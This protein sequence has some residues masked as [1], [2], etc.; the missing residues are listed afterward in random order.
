MFNLHILAFKVCS[1]NKA[2]NYY[3]L[4]CCTFIE[5]VGDNPSYYEL[6][7]KNKQMLKPVLGEKLEE[8]YVVA[9][10]LQ[11]GN[12]KLSLIIIL[13]IYALSQY[14]NFL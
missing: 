14:F 8:Y 9:N 5:V 4:S 11:N 6:Y 10:G 12:R 3:F 7:Q 13:F 1:I 2:N